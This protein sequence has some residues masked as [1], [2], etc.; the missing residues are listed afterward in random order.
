MRKISVEKGRS[1][2]LLAEINIT[3]LGD[4][5]L[6]LLIIIMIISPMVMQS[7][8]KV[9]ASQ[10][11]A[12]QTQMTVKS[13]PIILHIT[14]DGVYINTKKVKSEMDLSLRLRYLLVGKRKPTVLVSAEKKV[15]HGY[16]VHILD[17]ARQNGAEKIS[18]MQ[19]WGA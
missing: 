10:A 1:S 16:V 8:I 17:I 11:V 9:F 4:L 12:Q 5:S 15:K 3:P 13:A 14:E 7:M 2:E 18:L 19:S 6:T